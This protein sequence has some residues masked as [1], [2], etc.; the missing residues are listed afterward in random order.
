MAFLVGRYHVDTIKLVLTFEKK[1]KWTIFKIVY[2]SDIVPSDLLD[3]IALEMRF[4]G[5]PTT[6]EISLT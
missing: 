1:K 5:V 3:R 2:T 6:R 4:L